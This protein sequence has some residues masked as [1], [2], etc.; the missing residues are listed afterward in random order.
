MEGAISVNGVA[1]QADRRGA[2]YWP[3]RRLLAVADLHFE[4]GSSYARGAQ[5]LPPYDTAATLAALEESL[6]CFQPQRV[7]CL[8]DSFHDGEGPARM[9]EES[10]ARLSAMMQGRDWVWIVGNHDPA[11]PED[12]GGRI[13]E[14]LI[15]GG[16]VF[17]HQALN[18]EAPGEISGH[19]HPK[20]TLRRRGRSISLR[21][22]I[23]DGSRLILPSFGAYTGGLDVRAPEISGLFTQPPKLWLL[24]KDK[25][26]GYRQADLTKP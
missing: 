20:A 15:E 8:G 4:K 14:D 24:G 23:G 25:V 11:P 1:F 2:L 13:L 19:F 16:I 21:C 5:F 26:Y 22:F 17:R 9:P 3:E 10:R 18:R 12:L 7:I 6:A